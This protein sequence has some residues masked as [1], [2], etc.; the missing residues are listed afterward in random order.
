MT[1]PD[2]PRTL[3]AQD[4][5]P[6]PPVQR[7]SNGDPTSKAEADSAS[8]SLKDYAR[9]QEDLFYGIL[10]DKTRAGVVLRENKTSGR[11]EELVG[12]AGGTGKYDFGGG[13]SATE[14]WSA[15]TDAAL[16]AQAYYDNL[17]DAR[18]QLTYGIEDAKEAKD[19][20][21]SGGAVESYMSSESKKSKE[22]ERQYED[23]QDRASLLYDL[24]GD[25]QDM[26]MAADDQNFQNLDAQ[27][28][29]GLA[30]VEQYATPYASTSLSNVLRPSLPDYV[31]PDYR[32]NGAVGLPGPEGF[33]DPQYDQYGMPAYAFGTN[34]NM[35]P[36]P[37]P[38]RKK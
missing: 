22:I 34:P 12:G 28:K 38:W 26:A 17:L 33:D 5:P 10:A 37:W 13:G 3:K 14:R 36:R 23:F 11:V 18:R 31:R 7:E 2:N 35:E 20:A 4:N 24:M 21:G 1:Q 19:A 30:S 29:Y 27:R 15:S 16:E 32:L 8:S 25:E 9:T 6:L